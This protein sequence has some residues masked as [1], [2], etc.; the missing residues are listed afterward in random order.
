MQPHTT[1]AAAVSLDVATPDDA[2][3]LANLMQLYI[4]DLS[5]VFPD[6]SL[7]PDG[8]FTYPKLPLYWSEPDRRFPFL[9]RCGDQ[10][11]GFI[12]VTRG[13]P[14]AD[15]PDT[16]DV[17]EFFV[18]RR[19]R[20]AGVGRQAALLLWNR[21]PGKWTVRVTEA[22]VGGLAF[23]ERVVGEAAGGGVTTSTRPGRPT[24][25]RVFAFDSAS[26]R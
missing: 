2:T 26:S 7:G 3:L 15:D 24:P 10:P 11:A 6:V 18:L 19:Y 21:L 5:A 4:H 8:R 13:S 22:N 23:W 17:A 25:W 12:L 20:G 9:I 16:L 14:V 1:F